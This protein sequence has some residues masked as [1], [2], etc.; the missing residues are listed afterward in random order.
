MLVHEDEAVNCSPSL[1]ICTT[2]STRL[3]LVQLVLCVFRSLVAC[4]LFWWSGLQQSFCSNLYLQL[5]LKAGWRKWSCSLGC[6]FMFTAIIHWH[7]AWCLE[8]YAEVLA[9]KALQNNPPPPPLFPVTSFGSLC[10]QCVLVSVIYII[11]HHAC[12]ALHLVWSLAI[13]DWCFFSLSSSCL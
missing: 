10:A 4:T 9:W 8:T 12:K 3:H 1:L 7:I 13:V 5:S 2:L 11:F 6:V